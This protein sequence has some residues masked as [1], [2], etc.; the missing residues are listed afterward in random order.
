MPIQY[1]LRR[2]SPQPSEKARFGVMKER[3]RKK[4]KGKNA[5]FYSFCPLPRLANCF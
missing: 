5:L 1:F 4:K 2:D 3:K